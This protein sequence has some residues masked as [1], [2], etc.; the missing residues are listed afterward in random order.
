MFDARY[1][2]GF[3]ISNPD[4]IDYSEILPSLKQKFTFL[5]HRGKHYS[6]ICWL[7]AFSPL[8]AMFS[9]PKKSFETILNCRLQMS[10][11]W[12]SPTI[13]LGHIL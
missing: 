7:L 1:L 13:H 8:S 5:R 9:S 4:V 12:F 3:V 2:E 10:S 6:R 11:N